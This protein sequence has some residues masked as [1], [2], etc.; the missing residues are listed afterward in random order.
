MLHNVSG[1]L[2]YNTAVQ[3]PSHFS[4]KHMQID[5]RLHCIEYRCKHAYLGIHCCPCMGREW[6]ISFRY[7]GG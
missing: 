7:R 5:E 6:G 2:Q 3:W 4:W 1:G